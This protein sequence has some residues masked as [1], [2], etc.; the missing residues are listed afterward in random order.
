MNPVCGNQGFLA[1][2]GRSHRVDSCFIWACIKFGK[3]LVVQH[4]FSLG[5][6]AT[7]SA[8]SLIHSFFLSPFQRR[9]VHPI[10]GSQKDTQPPKRINIS[11][12]SV[13]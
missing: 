10:L 1:L 3:F 8:Q 7:Y 12:P 11:T 9:M 6:Q 5:F 2:Q 4:L 13:M